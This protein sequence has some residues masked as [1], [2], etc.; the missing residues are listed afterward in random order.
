MEVTIALADQTGRA[1]RFCRR[2]SR[3]FAPFA[4]LAV[5]L[6][7]VAVGAGT[8]SAQRHGG[9][10]SHSS[11]GSH[12]S[13]SSGSHHST[14][15]SHRSSS[16]GSHHRS[17]HSRVGSRVHAPRR[18]H[19]TGFRA[20]HHVVRGHRTLAYG[21][22]R[23]ADGRIHRSSKARE[24]FEKETGYP[25]GRPGYVIDHVVPLARGGADA[26]SNMQW[27]TIADAKAKDRWE[28]K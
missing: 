16:I 28:L 20:T 4:R 21:V 24:D 13:S 7:L 10:S 18:V 22:L 12:H 26:P 25:H 9:G 23:D 27:Q 14:S 5:V 3:T 19:T 11:G 15:G 6:L 1:G 2:L 17:S 8:A